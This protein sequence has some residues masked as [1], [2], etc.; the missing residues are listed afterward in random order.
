MQMG[1]DDPDLEWLDARV[2]QL[3]KLPASKKCQSVQKFSQGSTNF[4][5]D[6]MLRH[7]LLQIADK[8]FF[9]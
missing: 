5:D 4:Y 3:L 7:R 8:L 1:V 9:L 2:K 6:Q